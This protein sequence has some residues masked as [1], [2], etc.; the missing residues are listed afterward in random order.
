MNILIAASYKA[1]KSGNFIPSLL[2]LGLALRRQGDNVCFLFPESEN[3]LKDHSWRGWLE[4]QGFSVYLINRDAP[5]DIL[6]DQ[7]LEIIQCNQISI[8]HTHFGIFEKIIRKNRRRLPVKILI[9]DHFGFEYP[10]KQVIRNLVKSILFR[11]LGIDV[12]CVNKSVASSFL[13]TR[14]WYVP[15]GLS[16]KRNLEYSQSREECRA[17]LKIHDEEKVC[18]ILGWDLDRKGMD[19]AVKAVGECQSKGHNTVL[20]IV[21]FGSGPKEKVLRYIRERG[22]DPHSPWIRYWDDTEDIFAYHRAADVFLSSSRME[23]FPYGVLEA[24]SQN[25][26]IALSDIEATKWA[27]SYDLA[28]P[29]PVEDPSACADSIIKGIQAGRSPSNYESIINEYSIENWYQSIISIYHKL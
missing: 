6:I 12:V 1:S 17:A 8:L 15:N 27:S 9:H 25:T 14:H 24:I 26:P 28:F 21:G 20:C 16:F 11:L 22:I 3:A 29:Y 4:E 5:A 7:L 2:E 19:I 18:L 13:F 23:G 10:F